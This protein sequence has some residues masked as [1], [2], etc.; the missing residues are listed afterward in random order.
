MIVRGAVLREMGLP[1]PY[2]ES[3]PL[4]VEEVE[5][6]PPGPGEL[7]VRIRAAGLC[8]SDLSVIDGSRPRV[9]P[10][11]LG[12]EA[13]GEVVVSNA[14]GFAPGDVIACA[15]VPACGT[16]APCTDGRPALCE[17][18]AT[19]NT[20]GTLLSGTRRLTTPTPNQPPDATPSPGTAP[21]A[22]GSPAYVHH[23]LGVSGFAEHAVVSARSAVKM[24]PALPPE[25]AALFGCAV[26][27]GVG[28][29]VN[30]A[31]VRAGRSTAIFG[32]GGVGLSALLGA[33]LVGAHPIVAVDV[34]PSKLALARSLGA[35][36][37]VDAR[38]ADAVE[39]VRDATAGGAEYAF[40]T[41]GS[42]KVLE[43]A[44]AAT[45]RGGTTV[46]VGL[47]HPSQSFSVPAVSLVAEERRVLGSYLGSSVPSRDI[48]RYVALYQA[49]RL[50]VDR[51]L[52]ATVGLDDLNQAFD[53]L[54][55]GTSIRQV[56]LF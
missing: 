12:H 24:D 2:A 3:R 41:V 31:Q 22:S 16:C 38:D 23:H 19:A 18:A 27:T 53:E 50:P 42:A 37:V 49:G 25:I 21:A 45:H 26:M 30:T 8:H 52:T 28:A 1:A 47:P 14:P 56:L 4:R 54:A 51:L 33:V 5:L 32:L 35:T 43:Q 20:A 6:A 55:A 29:V 13:T 17:P 40:E 11:L 15:F 48:P 7:L 46:T 9:M 44:Y 39:Q 10:M 36:A 34:V